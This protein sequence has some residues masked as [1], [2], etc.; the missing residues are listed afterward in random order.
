[1]AR[2]LIRRY[3]PNI[4]RIRTHKHMRFFGKRLQDPNLWHLNRDSVAS[5]FA[6]GAFW[7]FV[8]MPMQMLPA[9]A[10]AI[11]FRANLPIVIGLVWLTNPVTAAPA[12][13]FCYWVGA[14][15]LSTPPQEF[16]FEPSWSWVTSEFARVWQPFVLGCFVVSTAL[17]LIGYYGM[18]ALWRWHVLRDWE[19]RHKRRRRA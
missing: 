17:A 16:A 8:P 3:L 14:L 2:R 9:T 19:R 4:D 1:M 7:A 15:L 12:Y 18:H 13:Y 5:A 6:I 10:F 11:Y